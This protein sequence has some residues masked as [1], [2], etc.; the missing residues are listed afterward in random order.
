MSILLSC[1]GITKSFGIHPLFQEISMSVSKGDRLGIIGPNGAG[2]S[3]FLKVL[4]GL[5]RAD[6][7][8]VH[9]S[10]KVHIEYVPQ[11]SHFPDSLTVYS[12][13]Y[14]KLKSQFVHEIELDLEVQAQVNKWGF[15]NIHQ[16]V[17]A[18][19]GGWKKR[20]SIALAFSIRPDIIFFDEPTNHLDIEGVLWLEDILQRMGGTYLIISHDRA[21]LEHVTTRIVELNRCYPQGLFSAKGNY[22]QF[23]YQREVFLEG[24]QQHERALASRV[25]REVE[26]LQRGPKARTTKADARV[27]EAHEFIGKLSEVRARNQTQQIDI[28]FGDEKKRAKKLLEAKEVGHSIDKKVL[29]SGINLVLSPGQ[30]LGLIGS[31]GSGKTTLLKIL[32]GELAPTLGS[33]KMAEGLQVVY[34][35]QNREQLNPDLSLRETLSPRGDF[36]HYRG[37]EVHVSGWAKR[38][39]FPTDQ[40]VVPIRNLSGGE[41]ARVMIARMM[42]RPADLLILD[43][44]TNDLDIPTLEVLATCIR[45]FNGA[46]VL[47]SH[48]RYFLDQAAT[49]VL[50]LDGQGKH[51]EFADYLQWESF[52]KQLSKEAQVKSKVQNPSSTPSVQKSENK[53]A[54]VRLSYAENKELEGMEKKISDLEQQ[55]ETLKSEMEQ[56]STLQDHQI[57]ASLCAQMEKIQA[58]IEASY[59]RWEFLENK[60]QRYRES[61]F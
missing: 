49:S 58:N 37:Q 55:V 40:L 3:T 11:E 28:E 33:I 14:D 46:V 50:I 35:D 9:C 39:L 23:L 48:D 53:E 43:E 30:C 10:H 41:R 21:F 34:F 61:R 36:V 19:S 52:Q 25:R 8:Q 15:E 6:L 13:F 20:L 42:L 27:K 45:E 56:P 32:S 17:Q 38:F 7:G 44:P 26:W 2:K 16:K 60:Q 57:L 59:E 1:Q 51:Y 5:E 4:A 54:A 47:V 22:S 12:A 29:F 31:N 24:Q 18:L